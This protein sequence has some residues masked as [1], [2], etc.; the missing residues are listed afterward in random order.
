[1]TDFIFVT[2]LLAIVGVVWSAYNHF[3][4]KEELKDFERRQQVQRRLDQIAQEARK[5]TV[6]LVATRDPWKR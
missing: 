3:N 2:Y 6:K 1:M 5:S 4:L